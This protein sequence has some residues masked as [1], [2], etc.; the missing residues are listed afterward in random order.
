MEDPATEQQIADAHRSV[1]EPLWTEP[2]FEKVSEAVALAE[3]GTQLV[4]EARCGY[5]PMQFRGELDEAVRLIALD[6]KRA[7][8]DEAR[9]RAGED[10][11]QQIFYIPERVDSIS[12]ADDVFDS[13]VC[14]NGLITVRQADEGIEELARVTVP[15]GCVSVAVPLAASFQL[16]YDMLDEAFRAHEMTEKLARLDNLRD[17]FVRPPR[18]VAL[19]EEAGLQVEE[20]RQLEWSVSFDTGREFLYSPLVRETFF[21]H[22]IGL[23]SA[24]D[25]DRVMRYIGEAID[26]YFDERPIETNVAAGFM[27]ARK[28]DPAG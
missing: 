22:W 26:T 12:Y 16:F 28:P 23:I 19:A 25:R 15:G 9:E 3:S 7:M 24:P 18:M 6:P 5:L 21:P 27:V 14:F 8:L 17:S 10:S 4:A 1:V 2:L 11:D 20:I 13:T